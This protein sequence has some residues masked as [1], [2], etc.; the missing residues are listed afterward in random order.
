MECIY[1]HASNQT[2]RSTCRLWVLAQHLTIYVY[3]LCLE[4]RILQAVEGR[5]SQER[6]D[7]HRDRKMSFFSIRDLVQKKMFFNLFC[8]HGS[9]IEEKR[10]PEEQSSGQPFECL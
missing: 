4:P 8:W 9:Q 5:T 7:C 6:K 1:W 2:T 3:V 10:H